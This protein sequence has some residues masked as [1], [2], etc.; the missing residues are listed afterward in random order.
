[1]A[2]ALTAV[3][4]W[5][6]AFLNRL[7]PGERRVLAGQIARELRRSQVA[8]IAA[9]ENP[10]G[11]AFKARKPQPRKLRDKIGTIKR[12]PMFKKLRLAQRLKIIEASGQQIAIGFTGRDAHI[13]RVHQDG[14][15]Q[16]VGTRM[17]TYPQRRLLGIT[18]ADSSH[19]MDTVLAFLD[20]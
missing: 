5:A 7:E 2:D 1:M 4:D 9:Q 14:L 17:V 11:S 19:L 20:K 15:A 18:E 6:A 12:G 16:K 8:R 13:A 10:D 3:E